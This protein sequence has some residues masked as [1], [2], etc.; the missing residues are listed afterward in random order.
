MEAAS[1]V[2]ALEQENK[3][4][5]EENKVLTENFNSE[6]VSVCKVGTCVQSG[7]VCAKWVSVCKVCGEQETAGGEQSPDRELQQ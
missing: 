1:K 4:L 3:K 7:Y 5:L 6:R 2:K